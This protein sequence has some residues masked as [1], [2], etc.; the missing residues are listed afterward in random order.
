MS[1]AIGLLFDHNR[2]RLQVSRLDSALDVLAFDGKEHLSQPYRYQIEFT[3]PELD[4]AAEQL[5]GRSACFSL[6]P[7][8]QQ[9]PSLGL[10]EPEIKPLRT[11]YG[12]IGAFERLSASRDEARY[13]VT[14]QPRLARLGLGRQYRIYQDQSVPQ[15]VE[16]ILRERHDFRGE[17]FLFTLAREYPRREQVMQ[18]GESDL[19]FIS[20][21]L[22][23]VGIWY[24]FSSDD[25]LRIEVVEFHDDTRHYQFGLELPLLSPSGLS[26]GEQDAVWQL[27]ASHRVVEKQV[28]I[29]AYDHRQAHAY[30]D[31]EIDHT[32]GAL[33]T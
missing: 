4:L 13:Q 9:L 6:Q 23:E 8:P 25:R 30:L 1:T 29:R 10:P 27:Q 5:L 31:G 7:R 17:D 33:T 18:Y 11:C 2:H 21:L 32:R 15:I 22:A 28:N 20:R 14:L 24:R 12:V 26:S 16:K 3:C 19:A